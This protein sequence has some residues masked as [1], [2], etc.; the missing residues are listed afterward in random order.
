MADPI[1]HLGLLIIDMQDVFLKSISD[2]ETV[3]QRT[4]FAIEAAA[5]LGCS[6]AITEQLPEKL[7]KSSITVKSRLPE[8]TPVFSKHSFSALEADGI[9]RWIESAQIEHLLIAGIESTICV[10]QTAVQAISSDIG[11][12]ILSDCISERRSEDQAPVLTQLRQ[13]GAHVLPSESI[14]YSLLSSAEHPKFKEFTQL[15]KLAHTAN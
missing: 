7:G 2:S 3:L 10:Y 1:N 6:I 9:G 11:V 4:E 13:L 12:T 14:F 8:N 5:L 15:V